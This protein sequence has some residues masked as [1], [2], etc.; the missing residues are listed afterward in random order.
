MVF[1]NRDRTITGAPIIKPAR[2]RTE[3]DYNYLEPEDRRRL[4]RPMV[5]NAIIMID[6]NKI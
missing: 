4:E 6:Q 1:W 2:K 3:F 5:Y